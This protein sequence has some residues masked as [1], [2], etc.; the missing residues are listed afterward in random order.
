MFER[1]LTS[2]VYVIAATWLL[3]I[4][5]MYVINAV[6]NAGS[7]MPLSNEAK[8]TLEKTRNAGSE[9]LQYLA[10][11]EAVVFELLLPIIGGAVTY[12]VAKS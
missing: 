8:N 9:S 3:V 5:G 10:P 1:M 2:K 4:V 12:G 11:D 7:Q 6:A